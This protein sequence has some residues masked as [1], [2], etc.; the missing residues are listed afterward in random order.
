MI[1]V[2]T[3]KTLAFETR[4]LLA[5]A[6]GC[7]LMA[8]CAA[9]QAPDASTSAGPSPALVELKVLDG[10]AENNKTLNATFRETQRAPEFSMVQ[11]IVMSGGSVSSSMFILRGVCAVMRARG[12]RYGSSAAVPG[13]V[14][15]YRVTFPKSPTAEQQR[16]RGRDLVSLDDCR[17]LK[18]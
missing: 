7:M 8:G 5:M 10:P 17:L 14:G 9:P 4:V 1:G 11:A 2:H 6:A 3:M 16:G 15:T 18:F 13:E 12:E